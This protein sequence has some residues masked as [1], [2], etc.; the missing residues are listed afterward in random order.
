MSKAGDPRRTSR[1]DAELAQMVAQVAQ[2]ARVDAIICATDTGALAGRLHNLSDRFR[3]IVAT[4]NRDT[5]DALTRTDLD[6]ILLP[7]R[8][9]NK[10]SQVRH[11]ISVAL[12]A[13]RVAMGDLVVCAISRDVYPEEGDLVVLTDVE[14][15]IEHL[16]L[17]DVLRLTDGIQL[18][19]MEAAITVAGKVGRAARRGKRIGAIFMLGDSHKVLEGSKQLVPNP[20]QGHDEAVRRITNSDIHGA[21]VELSK[22]DGAFVVRGD[23]FIQSAGVFLAPADVEIELPVGLG[24]RHAAAAAVTK[25]TI[26]TAVVVSATDGNVRVF[27]GGKMVLQM[28]PEVEYGPVTVEE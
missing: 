24:A 18:P 12:K 11:V 15:S 23:G 4:T 9:A 13:S 10:Y 5:A 3:V 22:L 6:T 8:A 20:F 2:A 26:A 25:R 27:S 1:S 7:L 21:L 19:V 16:P 14:P 17:S 28:D